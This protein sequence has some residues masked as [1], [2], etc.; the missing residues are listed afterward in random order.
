MVSTNGQVLAAVQRQFKQWRQQRPRSRRIPGELWDAAAQ[1]AREYG[2]S[3]TSRQ[4]GVDYYSLKR[5]LKGGGSAS[6]PESVEFVE[7]PRKVLSTGPACI[8]ELVDSKG[9]KLRMELRDFQGAEGL[10]KALWS[11]RG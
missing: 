8:L 7:I 5:R 1:A 3:K 10:A 4:L 11:A 6:P 2:V 9:L